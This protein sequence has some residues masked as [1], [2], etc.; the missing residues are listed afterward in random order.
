[1]PVVR[2]NEVHKSFG[3]NHLFKDLSLKI[4]RREKLGLIGQNGTGKTTLFKMI[5]GL[6]SPDAGEIIQKKNTNIGYLPQEPVFSGDKTVLEEMHQSLLHIIELQKKV[7]LAAAQLEN[8]SGN[9]LELALQEYDLLHQDFELKGGYN[10]ENRLRA[11][12]DGV[13]L[14]KEHYNTLTSKLSGGQLSRLGLAKVLVSGC[15][16]LLLDEPTNHLDLAAIEWLEKFLRT[17]PGG[18]VIISHDRYLLDKTAVKIIELDEQKANLWKGNYSNYTEQKKIYLIQKERELEK[19]KAS[20][21]K[22]ID[23]IERNRND[24]GM[25]KVARG[26]AAQLNKLLK[27][28]PDYLE[29]AKKRRTLKFQFEKI[30]VLSHKVL[31]C[32]N[33]SKKY[34]D[35]LLFENL[36][37]NLTNGQK[38]CITGPNGTGKSTLLKIVLGNIKPTT[39]TAKFGSNLKIGYLDQHGDELI[40]ENTIMEEIQRIR[41]DMLHGEIRNKLGAFL[42]SG[43]DPFKQ[44]NNLSGGEQNRLMLC[45][46]VMSNPDVLILDEPT[47]HLDIDSKEA[48]EN[49]ID[50]FDGTVIAVSH[51]RF[52]INKV[53]SDLL[54]MGVDELG[55]KENGKFEFIS[56]EKNLYSYYSDLIDK[57]KENAQRQKQSKNSAD[58]TKNQDNGRKPKRQAPE[59]I[60]HLNKYRVEQIEALIEEVECK[61]SEMKEKF[62]LE[63]YYKD[64]SKMAQLQEMVDIEQRELE[65]LY[66]A[67]EYKLG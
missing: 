35:L 42:F 58:S 63:E 16:L 32:C 25:S 38:L 31:K 57:N 67:Y 66:L 46:L 44:V 8:L 51:D 52:F 59:E 11:I 49:A 24:V 19:R 43:D 54:V 60:K 65:L 12:L 6:E 37:F 3:T 15:D 56:S 2:I 34:D 18:A 29:A 61:I 30:N 39:G 20:V 33:L 14:T 55:N 48:L 21:K 26:R 7:E 1:M 23:F 28:N 17:Y 40:G 47:N 53:A 50:S 27:E 45:K 41:P 9:K 13:G 10:Y 22:E 4:F 36:D 64:H 5:L 62:G